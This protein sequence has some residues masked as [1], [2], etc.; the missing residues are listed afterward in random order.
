MPQLRHQLLEVCA[1]KAGPHRS[2]LALPF[3]S[4]MRVYNAEDDVTGIMYQ[5]RQIMLA[6]SRNEGLQCGG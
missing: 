4:L 5:A 2:C 6:T 1:E 3:K